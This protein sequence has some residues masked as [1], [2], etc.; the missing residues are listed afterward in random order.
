MYYTLAVQI[1][2]PLQNL[3]SKLGDDVLC[4]CPELL[5]HLEKRTPRYELQ[6]YVQVRRRSLQSAR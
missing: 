6:E 2:H 1:E 5:K 4:E 3:T